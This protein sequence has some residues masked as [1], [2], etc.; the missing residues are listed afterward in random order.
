MECTGRRSATPPSSLRPQPPSPRGR[1]RGRRISRTLL[2][3][4]RALHRVFTFLYVPPRHTS[5]AVKREFHLPVSGQI[6]N[7][8]Q[9]VRGDFSINNCIKLPTIVVTALGPVDLKNRR[10]V[11]V[12]RVVLLTRITSTDTRHATYCTAN[13]NQ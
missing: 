6:E 9:C 13:N 1:S 4:V 2:S 12:D 8:V 5:S 10:T 7:L 3:I 11:Y